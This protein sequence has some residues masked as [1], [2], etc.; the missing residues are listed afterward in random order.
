MGI[1]AILAIAGL[2][3]PPAAAFIN[4]KFLKKGEDTT[5]STVNSLATTSPEVIPAFI[6]A[7]V[8]LLKANIEWFNRDYKGEV[9]VWVNDLRASIRP[10]TVILSIMIVALDTTA[11]LSLT[12]ETRGALLM[13]ITSWFSDRIQ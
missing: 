4:K 9:S 8:D 5:D 3:V 11:G 6:Q 7:K 13:N 12:D 1:E 2:I 10:V